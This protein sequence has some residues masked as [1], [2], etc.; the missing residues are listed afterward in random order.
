MKANLAFIPP[1]FFYGLPTEPIWAPPP[2]LLSITLY[3]I[4]ATYKGSNLHLL[5]PGQST[6]QV[7]KLIRIY[8]LALQG[9]PLIIH[10]QSLMQIRFHYEQEQINTGSKFS[11]QNKTKNKNITD[12]FPSLTALTSNPGLKPLFSLQF[13]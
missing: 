2:T 9:Q 8:H 11:K 5:I 3:G 1:L 12:L 7:S 13:C 6:W 4:S 10:I